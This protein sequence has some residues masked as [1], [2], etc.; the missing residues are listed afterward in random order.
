MNVMVA[1]MRAW[2]AKLGGNVT[3]ERARA[4]C[5]QGP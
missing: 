4:R 5:C 2:P 1:D 3:P